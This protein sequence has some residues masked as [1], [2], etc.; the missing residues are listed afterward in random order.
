V[1]Q[2]PIAGDATGP[3]YTKS[4]TDVIVNYGQLFFVSSRLRIT[5]LLHKCMATNK[6]GLLIYLF[7]LALLSLV[8]INLHCVK[9]DSQREEK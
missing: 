5:N 4:F 1:P 2:C 9:A 6:F 7:I 8:Y 3:I